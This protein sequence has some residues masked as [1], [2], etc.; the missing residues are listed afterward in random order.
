MHLRLFDRPRESVA[1][2]N[3]YFAELELKIVSNNLCDLLLVLNFSNCL[4]TDSE[5]VLPKKRSSCSANRFK[6]N[7]TK[8]DICRR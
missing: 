7:L 3:V 2:F 1:K 4:W 8:Y 6:R 5:I